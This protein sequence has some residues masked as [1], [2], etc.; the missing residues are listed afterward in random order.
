MEDKKLT[1]QQQIAIITGLKLWKVQ[2]VFA[3]NTSNLHRVTDDEMAIILH[4]AAD[5]GY[6][7]KGKGGDQKGMKKKEVTL[8]MVAKRAGV[9]ESTVSI[10]LKKDSRI[11]KETRDRIRKI[12]SALGYKPTK[13]MKIKDFYRQKSG[14]ELL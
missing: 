2:H 6:E 3:K 11:G 8:E 10:A 9:A 1:I 7:N 13:A 4:A 14:N 12:A 5:L